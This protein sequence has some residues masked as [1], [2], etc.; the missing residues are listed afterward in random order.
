MSNKNN[1]IV[2]KEH[3]IDIQ[4]FDIL[5]RY[6]LKRVTSSEGLL[7][8]GL[9]AWLLKTKT[10]CLT[11]LHPRIYQR[12]YN[13]VHFIGHL[14]TDKLNTDTCFIESTKKKINHAHII[15][16][17]HHTVLS[18]NLN[19]TEWLPHAAVVMMDLRNITRKKLAPC[20]QKCS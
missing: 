3:Y 4:R 7:L 5:Y 10:G 9:L 13:K 14:D 19:H 16:T 11:E 17:D 8:L 12:Y 6:Y 18:H 1:I 2:K 20:N 15:L